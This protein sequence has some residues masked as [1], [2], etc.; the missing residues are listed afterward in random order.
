MIIR[1]FLLWART[2]SAAD[3]A[4]GISALARAYLYSN[5][6]AE[7]RRD[8]ETAMVAALDDPSPLVRRALAE[9]LAGSAMAPRPVVVA[10]AGEQG[11]I[12]HLVLRRSPVL[13]DADLVDAAAF[14]GVCAQCA[15]AARPDLSVA[16]TAALVEIGEADV[17]RI[18]AANDGA[19]FTDGVLMQLVERFGEDGSVREGLLQRRDLPIAA[20][21][22][23]AAAAARSLTAF[24]VGIGWMAEP[25]GA[26]LAR[27]ANERATLALAGEGDG[28][29]NDVAAL[30]AHLI[31]SDQMTPS[32]LLRAILSR[33]EDVVVEAFA[34]LSGIAAGRVAALLRDRRAAGLPALYRRTGLPASLE[35]VFGAALGEAGA[36]PRPTRAAAGIAPAKLDAR[37]VRA[38]IA[39]CEA[40]GADRVDGAALA[41]LRRFEAEA[42]RDEAGLLASR[43][44]DEAALA[45][46]LEVAPE[47]LLPPPVELQPVD[48][49][50]EFEGAIEPADAWD[51]LAPEIELRAAIRKI[52]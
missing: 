12:A 3:R 19:R 24:S 5:L 33:A 21:Q 23:L 31:A 14:G 40:L 43:M 52:A 22:S 26:R 20:R 27:D 41:L 25:R 34:A 18:L 1:R 37:L 10:L 16:V 42:A 39:R 36:A 7:D 35:T 4:D 15:I 38:T 8:A 49:G 45:T 44:A 28:E 29:G 30:V 6:D 48:C 2:A 13:T 46:V 32:L 17:A 51:A 11:E 9:A 50:L 47:L